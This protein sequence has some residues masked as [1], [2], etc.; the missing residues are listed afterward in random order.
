MG[1]TETPHG[2]K[3]QFGGEGQIITTMLLVP[4]ESV[5]RVA[6]DQWLGCRPDQEVEGG[7]I[8]TAGMFDQGSKDC[9]RFTRVSTFGQWGVDGQLPAD[10][11]AAGGSHRASDGR[12]GVGGQ[13]QQPIAG[14]I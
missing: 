2:L 1:I 6:H 11:L 5:F 14:R 4:T 13:L 10:P 9:C 8:L 12:L 7:V 3:G